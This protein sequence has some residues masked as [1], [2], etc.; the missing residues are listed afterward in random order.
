MPQSP[1]GGEPHTSPAE[2]LTRQKH[3]I[4]FKAGWLRLEPGEPKMA[5]PG[6]FRSPLNFTI[7]DQQFLMTEALQLV[8]A[9]DRHHG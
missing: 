2:I 9:L 6:Y 8:P 5:K 4:N 7:I 1:A 3:H